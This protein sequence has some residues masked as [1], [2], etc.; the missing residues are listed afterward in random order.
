M[1]P[2]WWPSADFET[3][4]ARLLG[5]IREFFAAAGVM[6]VETPIASR[7][8]ASDPALD[9]LK[10]GWSGADA[11]PQTLYLHTSPEFLMKR[12]LASGS[13]PIFQNC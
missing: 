3:L 7:A 4:R 12:L 9:S 5:C 8:A 10:T 2:T 6:E 11:R 13:G 1:S